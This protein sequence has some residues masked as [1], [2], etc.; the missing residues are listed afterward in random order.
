M[1]IYSNHPQVTART[2]CTG[3]AN[4]WPWDYAYGSGQSTYNYLNTS[5]GNTS[6]GAFQIYDMTTTN[7]VFSWNG[8]SA[9]TIPHIGFGNNNASN[10][11][12]TS[13]GSLNWTAAVNGAYNF[14]LKVMVR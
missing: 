10:I 12:Y 13:V 3:L 4:I 7:T 8:H 2:G 9:S 11:N 6:Y 5:T 14:K 1:N